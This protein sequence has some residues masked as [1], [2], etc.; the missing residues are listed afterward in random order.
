MQATPNFD[1][2]TVQPTQPSLNSFVQM[3]VKIY[4]NLVAVINGKIGFGDGTNADNIDGVWVGIVTPV[5]PNTDLLVTHN[6][7][8]IPVGYVAMTKNAACDLYNGSVAPT[9]T[10][11]TLRATGS[12]VIIKLFIV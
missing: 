4:K 8:R 5:T 1:F 9:T 7:G 3:L 2:T 11:I 10:Q 6:L 12:S